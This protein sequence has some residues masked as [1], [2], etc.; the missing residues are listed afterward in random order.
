MPDDF[1]ESLAT[2]VS[3]PNQEQTFVGSW[4]EP[5][6]IREV[7]ILGDQEALF[8]L[9]RLPDRPIRL[10]LELL[11]ADSLHVMTEATEISCQSEG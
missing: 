7:E 11:L 8:V 9:G 3:E 2:G 5:P 6:R 1:G 4:R 10:T